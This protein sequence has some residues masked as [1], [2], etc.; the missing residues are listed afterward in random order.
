MGGGGSNNV[1][2]NI[3][4]QISQVDCEALSSVTVNIHYYV[5]ERRG[6]RLFKGVFHQKAEIYS[7]FCSP[8]I[9]TT[10][11]GCHRRGN[12]STQAVCVLQLDQLDTE[13]AVHTSPPAGVFDQKHL[14]TCHF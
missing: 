1:N 8:L 14:R 13:P 3:Y 5:F 4:L 2:Y 6:G 12:N 10:M 7:I 11:M 9:H